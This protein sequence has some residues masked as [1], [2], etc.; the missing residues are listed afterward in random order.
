MKR[1]VLLTI[2][3]LSLVALGVAVRWAIEHRR[4]AASW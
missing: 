4:S 3:F 1:A 2:A